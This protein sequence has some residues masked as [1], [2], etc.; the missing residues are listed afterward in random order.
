MHTKTEQDT[1][2]VSEQNR[3]TLFS[4]DLVLLTHVSTG[5]MS[6]LFIIYP[7]FFSQLPFS[8]LPPPSIECV[9][10]DI[11]R[12]YQGQNITLPWFFQAYE[13][14]L[15]HPHLTAEQG[16]YDNY[17]IPHHFRPLC[18]SLRLW[19]RI[20]PLNPRPSEPL[21]PPLHQKYDTRKGAIDPFAWTEEYPTILH[22]HLHL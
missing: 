11:V 7:L 17:D 14:I 5:A 1:D 19:G 18:E 16:R 6:T 12:L 22:L 21:L 10:T 20:Y 2:K 15:L 13:S 9:A 4:Q 3:R 8:S